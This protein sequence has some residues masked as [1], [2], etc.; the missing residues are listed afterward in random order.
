MQQ[1][2]NLHRRLHQCTGTSL[3]EVEY[4]KQEANLPLLVVPEDSSPLFR[5]NWLK[6]IYLNW[7]EIKKTSLEL[8][9]L[10]SK[11]KDLFKEELGTVQEYDMSALGSF[12]KQRLPLMP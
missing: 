1:T 9:T 11:Y 10:L 5:R 8:D 6:L 7:P 2:Q 4:G 12:V 3:V